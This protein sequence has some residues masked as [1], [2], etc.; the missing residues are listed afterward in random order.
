[1]NPMPS[2]PPVR[3]GF[4]LLLVALFALVLASFWSLGLEWRALLSLDAA[5]STLEFLRGF[6]PPETSAPFLR[7]T[8]LAALETVAMSGL[9][10]L[11]AALF[12][13]LLALP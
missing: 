10:T 12:G 9:G 13:L 8:A 6:A 2:P 7:K 3:I 5:R 1:M 11:L 4:R